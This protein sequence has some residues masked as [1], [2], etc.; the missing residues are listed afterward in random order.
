VKVVADE[1]LA[2]LQYRVIDSDGMEILL[3]EESDMNS[4]QSK[5]KTRSERL[6]E[7]EPSQTQPQPSDSAP[8]EQ[9]EASKKAKKKKKKST[10][11]QPAEE[12]QQ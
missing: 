1:S 4:A 7:D 3:H 9:E 10:P 5:N 8:E 12:Q 2:Y 11:P 6:L